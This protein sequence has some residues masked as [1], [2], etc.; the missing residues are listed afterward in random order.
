MSTPTAENELNEVAIK[1][2]TWKPTVLRTVAVR[3]V[4]A[5]LEHR[6]VYPDEV[7]VSD[8]RAED[9]N[10]IGSAWRQLVKAGV[11]EMT[12]DFRG[13][14][15]KN[16]RGRIIHAYRLAS[17]SRAHTFLKRNGSK[18]PSADPQLALL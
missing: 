7:D 12:R 1:Q 10:C 2:L 4:N 17:K 5:V 16:A 14:T 18:P 11:I 15:A 9:V 3:V 6:V 13:S 8:V